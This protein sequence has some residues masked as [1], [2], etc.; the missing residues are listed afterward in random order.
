MRARYSAYALGR[1]DFLFRSWHPRTRPS[2]VR[3]DASLTWTGL[4]VL[5]A[6]GDVVEFRAH[7]VGPDGPGEIHETSRFE[8]RAGRW[9]Y[10]EAI[11]PPR[12]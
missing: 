8:E 11:E 3:G 4:D 9:V 7:F 12:A 10:V 5:R 2:E 6:E 1:T